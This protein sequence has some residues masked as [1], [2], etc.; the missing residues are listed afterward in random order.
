MEESTTMSTDVLIKG[1][2]KV[3]DPLGEGGMSMVFMAWDN[4]L[5][6]AVAVKRLKGDV[7]ANFASEEK[8]GWREAKA[9]AS[10]Q[11]PNIVT[12]FDYG[13]DEQGAYFVM[14]M[15]QGRN[16]EDAVATAPLTREDFIEVARQ[17]LAGL[18]AAHQIG[19]IHRD[20]KASNFMLGR[21]A[22]GQLTVKILDFGLAKF[23]MEPTQQTSGVDDGIMGSVYYMSPE[24]IERQPLDARSDL[25]SLGHAFYF[26]LTGR[27]AFDGTVMEIITSH[28]NAEPASLRDLRPDLEPAL[29]D[30]VHALMRKSLDERPSS[31]AEAL[32]Q[33]QQI[34][35]P[36]GSVPPAT[37]MGPRPAPGGN[38]SMWIAVVGGALVLTVAGMVFW[39]LK[40]R[41]KPTGGDAPVP[42][43]VPTPVAV[44]PPAPTPPPAVAPETPETPVTPPSGIPAPAPPFATETVYSAL[45]VK[46]LTPLVGKTI[47]IEGTPLDF[48]ENKT[49]T[50]L[51]VHFSNNYR[52]SVS[53]V[54]FK[55]RLAKDALNGFIGKKIR[56][57]GTLE[58]Y[59]GSL[60]IKPSS[61]DAIE[62][63]P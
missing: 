52:E 47:R 41:A 17:S 4:E 40:G 58:S 54:F 21:D 42:A 55:K 62:L 18:C 63:V 15:L 36:T 57:S 37:M 46:T 8:A 49:G 33:L 14:E 59:N 1:R 34:L 19:F 3:M 22:A 10:L 29:C 25:Y 35:K 38:A 32:A 48:G 2:Y 60:Q 24:Q 53:L 61:P 27:N 12:L 13:V 56:A 20:I 11:H 7:A 39:M 5:D 6:R 51:Y 23:Q 16:L 31:A 9:L 28:L 45:D 30:W 44:T 50:I 26:A 43:P